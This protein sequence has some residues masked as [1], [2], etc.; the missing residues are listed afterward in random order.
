MVSLDEGPRNGTPLRSKHL[1]DNLL[2][3]ERDGV[4]QRVK[5]GEVRREEELISRRLKDKGPPEGLGG[6]AV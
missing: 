3:N 1:G 2:D 4:S 6:L 5:S